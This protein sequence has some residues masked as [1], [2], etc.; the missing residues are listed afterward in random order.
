MLFN[1]PITLLLALAPAALLAAP[2]ASKPVR[3]GKRDLST[4]EVNKLLDGNCDMSNAYM[5]ISPQGLPNPSTGLT[6][7]HV[8]I[9]HGTQN[10][11][12]ADSTSATAPKAGGAFATLYNATCLAIRAPPIMA[13]MVNIAITDPPPRED[14]ASILESGHHEFTETGVPLFKLVTDKVNYGYVKAKPVA[15]ATAPATA[16]RGE[17]GMGSVLWLKLV[18]VEGDYKEVYRI[19]TAGGVAPKTCEGMA[20]HFEV[21]YATQYWFWK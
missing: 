4:Q 6:I 15:N 8:A 19:E 9:G 2:T 3:M 5:P 11:T 1:T 17:N 13:D 7:G 20:S 12:C 18:A 21:P 16:A 10:Y 14:I